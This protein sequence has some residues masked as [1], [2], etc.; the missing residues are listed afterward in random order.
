M[1]KE[2]VNTPNNIIKGKIEID[3]QLNKLYYRV[4]YNTQKENRKYIIKVKKGDVLTAEQA[5]VLKELNEIGYLKCSIT[6]EEICKIIKKTNHQTK[7]EIMKRFSILQSA[8]F[9]FTTGEHND[10]TTQTQLIGRV[11]FNEDTNNYTVTLDSKLYIYLFYSVGVGFTPI[12]L[13]VLFNLQSQYSQAL[14]VSLRSWSGVKRE[15]SY[16]LEQLR[17]IFNVKERYKQYTDFKKRTINTAIAE[18]NKTG[19]MEI[20]E[21]KEKK[22]GRKVNQITFVVNDYEPRFDT[23]MIHDGNIDASV[24]WLGYIKLENNNLL[25]RLEL[26]YSDKDFTSPIVR[27]IFHKAYDKTLSR[28]NRF[29]MIQDKKSAT[30][31]GLFCFIIE[32]EFLTNEL[33]AEQS[34]E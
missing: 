26:K 31:Y 16:T 4:L 10:I 27:K 20:V 18:I 9:R 12:N 33:A 6:K 13:A 15:I 23:K 25:E 19:S 5:A 1:V 29:T 28:D 32:G 8:I 34:L 14:Y 21:I 7:D 11:E 2:V 17:E 3:S 30:N 22:I 24:I